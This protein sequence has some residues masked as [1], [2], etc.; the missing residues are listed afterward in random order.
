MCQP[1]SFIFKVKGFVDWV[2]IVFGMSYYKTWGSNYYLSWVSWSMGQFFCND[3]AY[4]EMLRDLQDFLL[5]WN[6][7]HGQNVG[8]NCYKKLTNLVNI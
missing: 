1:R 6:V 2:W 3:Y 8:S 4:N 5:V 7:R